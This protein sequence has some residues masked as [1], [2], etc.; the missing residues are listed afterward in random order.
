MERVGNERKK[1]II[2]M[3]MIMIDIT[4][5]MLFRSATHSRP[6]THYYRYSP[7]GTALIQ[8]YGYGTTDAE[9]Q[10]QCYT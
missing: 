7:S 3:M 1:R 9:L 6:Q 5:Q 2:I 4:L 8:G 10:I